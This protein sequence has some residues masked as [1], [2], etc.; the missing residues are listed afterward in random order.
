MTITLFLYLLSFI[1]LFFLFSSIYLF[2]HLSVYLFIYLFAYLGVTFDR[3]L[4]SNAIK[5]LPHG[6]FAKLKNLKRL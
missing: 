2:I 1:P 4:S 3:D 5:F 6:V